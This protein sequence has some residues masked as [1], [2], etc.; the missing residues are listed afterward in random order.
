M[1]DSRLRLSRSPAFAALV[2]VLALLVRFAVPAGYMLAGDGSLAVVPCPALG[3]AVPGIAAGQPAAPAPMVGHHAMAPMEEHGGHAAPAE[4][5]NKQAGEN[6]PF[7]VMAAALP[8]PAPL[9]ELG[10][11]PAFA[12]L[13]PQPLPRFAA[14]AHSA[15]PLPAR[16]PPTLS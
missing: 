11:P 4:P 5:H 7:G 9:A 14:V 1:S 8:P 6:C 3:L 13:R 15:P 10:Q 2:L 16:G 12:E